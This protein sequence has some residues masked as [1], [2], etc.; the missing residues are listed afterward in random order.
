MQR[1]GAPRPISA[2]DAAIQALVAALASAHAPN[3]KETVT[4]FSEAAFT[5]RDLSHQNLRHR[6][7]LV[8]TKSE[9]KRARFPHISIAPPVTA[10]GEARV[11]IDIFYS[12]YVG[13][14]YIVTIR[15]SGNGWDAR[16][17]PANERI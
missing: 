8:R 9:Y 11:G 12:P 13:N 6:V 15:R 10:K 5:L 7:H 1:G 3:V 16:V 2:K 4:V 17:G 14:P